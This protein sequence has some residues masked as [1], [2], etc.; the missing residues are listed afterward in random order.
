MVKLES[1]SKEEAFRYMGG[2]FSKISDEELQ[3]L[4]NNEKLLLNE[5]NVR[6]IYKVFEYDSENTTISGKIKLTG[7][8]IRNH[9]KD[10][11]RVILLACTLSNAVDAFIRKRG[12]V[13][14][15]DMLSADALASVAI[16]DSLRLIDKELLN[17]FSDEY[18]TWRFGVGYGDFPLEFQKTFLELTNAGK[19][20]GLSLSDGGLLTPTKSVTCVIGISENPLPKGRSMDGSRISKCQMCNMRKTGDFSKC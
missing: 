8:S 1:I 3:I 7:D 9:L 15:L 20:I 16:E 19:L 11:N 12:V 6:Y 5:I 14:M 2:D 18:L 10:C 17:E 13:S 4:N